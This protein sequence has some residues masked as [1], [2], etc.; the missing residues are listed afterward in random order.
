MTRRSTGSSHVGLTKLLLLMF[1]CSGRSYVMS[2]K[3]WKLYLAWENKEIDHSLPCTMQE[4]EEVT[5]ETNKLKTKKKRP[6][7]AQLLVTMWNFLPQENM[8]A[9]GLYWFKLGTDKL[10]GLTKG[11]QTYRN[12]TWLRKSCSL[13]NGLWGSHIHGHSAL[14]LL[15]QQIPWATGTGQLAKCPSD[16]TWAA[17]TAPWQGP[18][19]P[20][21][22]I[23]SPSMQ[24]QGCWLSDSCSCSPATP[25][26]GIPRLSEL[27]F[28]PK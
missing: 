23:G 7:S 5:E 18:L 27:C 22:Y 3:I 6:F 8:G 17:L 28:L 26:T 1:S 9:R 11:Y 16:L 15:P 12:H 10:M 19:S 20:G 4:P 25:L 13:A 14:L 21:G 2:S 24:L